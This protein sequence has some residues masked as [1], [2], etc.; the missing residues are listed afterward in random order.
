MKGTG[1]G[2]QNYVFTGKPTNGTIQ[3]TINGG[4]IYLLG[5]PYAS[6][7]DADQFIDDNVVAVDDNGDIATGV[8]ASTGALY[9]WEHFNTNNS[10]ILAQ[11]EGG[12]ATYNKIGGVIA[13]ADAGVSSNGTGSIRPGRYVPVGQGFFVK[14]TPLGGVV[15]FNNNQR[16]FEKEV[17]AAGSGK[18]YSIF[19][20]TSNT[21]IPTE[22]PDVEENITLSIQ[23]LYFKFTNTDGFQRELLLG[24]KE[25]LADGLNY[26]YDAMLLDNFISDCSWLLNE[27][28][29]ENLVI[30]GIGSVY[31]NLQLPLHIKADKTGNFKFEVID[32]SD[33]DSST[34][35][36]LYDKELDSSF[37]L[38]AGVPVEFYLEE[39]VYSDRFKVVFKVAKIEE[40]EAEEAEEVLENIDTADNLVVFYNTKTQ[41]I[42][43]TNTTQFSA[44]NISIHNV[45]GQ[46]VVNMNTEFKDQNLITIPVSLATGAYV[47]TFDYDNKR[48]VTKKLMI[49]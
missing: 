7:L 19:T 47:I 45:L 40:A 17:T 6:A 1:A 8:G 35:V 3:H 11:Y 31:D 27:N 43:I 4:D 33:I 9:F 41:S 15:E 21:N 13:V 2:I 42:D 37:P 14:A 5:N 24:I 18:D 16:V 30:Q 34:S 36:Y 48:Q 25:G 12:Y 29:Q 32:L 49:R 20:R 22:S 39:G 26:G 10:H 44:K 23:R 38:E 28:S 46:K